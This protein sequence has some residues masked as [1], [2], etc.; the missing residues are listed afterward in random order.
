MEKIYTCPNSSEE[1]NELSVLQ[2]DGLAISRAGPWWD[3][4]IL[5]L[6]DS[7]SLPVNVI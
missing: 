1:T 2:T 3:W 4:E 7:L 5:S 6:I